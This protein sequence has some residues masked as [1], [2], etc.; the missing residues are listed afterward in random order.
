MRVVDSFK[1]PTRREQDVLVRNYEQNMEIRH[2]N[3]RR[4]LAGEPSLQTKKK[5][6]ELSPRMRD[7]WRETWSERRWGVVKRVGAG[8]VLLGIALTLGKLT[9]DE[10][11]AAT[12]PPSIGASQV[13][14]EQNVAPGPPPP[15]QHPLSSAVPEEDTKSTLEKWGDDGLGFVKETS[16]G[17]PYVFGAGVLAFFVGGVG[18]REARRSKE[19]GD[20]G[21]MKD[22]LE[23]WNLDRGDGIP[24][25]PAS[26]YKRTTVLDPFARPPAPEESHP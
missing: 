1:S 7:Q 24:P 20:Y 4:A 19:R 23:V 6:D 22:N 18:K 21:A 12:T 25:L 15:E 8:A 17:G 16:E 2:E 14:G 5:K 3:R 9:W 13:P 26:A 11:G 10:H